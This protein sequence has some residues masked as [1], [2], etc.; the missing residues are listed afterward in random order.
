MFRAYCLFFTLL[1]LLVLL[2]FFYLLQ[3]LN[4]RVQKLQTS[5]DL[6][7]RE[8]RGESTGEIDAMRKRTKYRAESSLRGEI[9]CD[10]VKR[11]VE[12]LNISRTGVL[13]RIEVVTLNLG[14]SYPIFI[15]LDEHNPIQTEV[16]IVRVLEGGTQYG[17]SFQHI[18]MADVRKITEFISDKVV[19]ELSEDY[20]S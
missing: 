12:V 10:G 2:F 4:R 19:D 1:F 3:R 11:E 14:R 20:S 17:C 5:M 16:K 7:E 18:A 8:V 9:D 6:L 13:F 15:W